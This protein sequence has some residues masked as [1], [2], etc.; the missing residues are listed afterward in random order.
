MS[1]SWSSG[2]ALV[3]G[4][5]IYDDKFV[6]MKY[7]GLLTQ[8]NNRFVNWDTNRRSYAEVPNNFLLSFLK[9]INKSM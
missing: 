5:A 6:N 9:L 4:V 7:I 1:A 2:Y 8:R 3:T